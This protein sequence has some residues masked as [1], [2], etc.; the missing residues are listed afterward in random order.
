MCSEIKA[1]RLTKHIISKAQELGISIN[2]V[3]HVLEHPKTTAPSLLHPGQVRYTGYGIAVMVD[4]GV[5]VTVYLDTVRTPLRP[6]QI[7]AGV[8]I[9]RKIKA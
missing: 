8:C 6:D 9:R 3:E 7:K 2:L 1:M 4:D 5:A